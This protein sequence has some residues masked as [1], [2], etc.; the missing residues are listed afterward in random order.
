L[1]IDSKQYYYKNDWSCGDLT[2]N[3]KYKIIDNNYLDII[4]K[5]NGDPNSLK[6]YDKYSIQIMS[7]Y[8][9]IIYIP[10]SEVTSDTISDFGYSSLPKCYSLNSEQSLVASGVTKL[11]RIPAIN[12]R[13][14]GVIVGIIDTGIDYSNHVFQHEDGTSKILAIWDQSIDNVNQYPNITYP[15]LYGTEYTSEQIN[16]ALRS[17]NPMQI[18]PS[19]DE[20]GHG[21][22]LAGIAAGSEN[23]EN[24]FSGVVPDAE[25]IVVKLKQAKK[26]LTD[27]FYIPEGVPC[28]QENDIIWAIRYIVYNARRLNRPVA[29]CIGLGTSQ[30]SHDNSGMLNTVTSIYGDAANVAISVAAGN[31]GNS[32]RHFYSSL[33]PESGPVTVELNVGADESGFSMELWGD[34]PTIYTLDI[35]SPS[36][37]YIPRVSE[38]LT[39]SQKIKFIF[40]NTI[41]YLDYV[42][43]E[44][45]TGKQ[46]IIMRFEN[47]TMGI[48]RFKVYGRGDLKGTFHIWLPSGN[49][50]SRNTYFISSNPF[51]TIT[52]PGNNIVSITVTAYDSSTEALYPDSGKGFS[53]SNII[54]PTLAAPGVNILCPTLNHGFTS[55]S[56]TSAAT[57]HA[58]GITAMLLEWCVVDNN[59][60][61]I[62]TVGIKNFL[63]RGAK[64]NSSLSYPNQNWGYGII[65]VYNSFNILRSGIR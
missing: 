26:V 30:G 47:P 42:M 65:D 49:F 45:E 25:L 56:G 11:R 61:G 52:S 22:M 37:E 27:F 31:E 10:I 48:W 33:E 40:E 34:P 62:D 59:Y 44:S 41:I 58:A 60:P 7:D 36:G 50:I 51:T 28:Y 18:V 54:N 14:K 32:S 4:I 63:I 29:L 39:E 6:Q 53:T 20:I 24:N 15:T 46:I 19:T 13:G 16:L 9:A 17:E 43:I 35:L 8:I 21:T 23:N 1:V 55:I 3:E 38:L 57:A 12:L 64:R 2:E 5:Y